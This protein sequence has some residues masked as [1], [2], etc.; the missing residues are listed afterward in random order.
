LEEQPAKPAAAQSVKGREV[1]KFR[2]VIVFGMS[3]LLFI[4]GFLLSDFLSNKKVNSIDES[5]NDVSIQT[6]SLETEYAFLL[7]NPC[8]YVGLNKLAADLDA[9]GKKMVFSE[10][11]AATYGGKISNTKQQYFLLE[12]KHLLFVKKI[13]REC[14]PNYSTVLYFYSDKGDC[15]ICKVQGVVLSNIKELDPNVMIYSFDINSDFS[16]V[17]MLKEFYQVK[18]APT[19]VINDKAY[20]GLYDQLTMQAILKKH[21]NST[22]G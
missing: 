15:D 12:L 22:G 3:T 6:A 16:T 18:T 14:S 8:S 4:S 19:L 17:N 5:L 9:L 7:E 11:Q 1:D 21:V 20:E 13:N 10:E 2:V